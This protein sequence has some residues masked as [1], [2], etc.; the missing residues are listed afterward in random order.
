M[1]AGTHIHPGTKAIPAQAFGVAVTP[2]QPRLASDRP[3]DEWRN[4]A[5][6]VTNEA[7]KMFS[8]GSDGAPVTNYREKPHAEKPARP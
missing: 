2:K 4:A 5:L 6:H 3:P 1:N 8:R 7:R